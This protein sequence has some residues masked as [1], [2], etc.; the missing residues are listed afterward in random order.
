MSDWPPTQEEAS[1]LPV[2]VLGLRLLTRVR[3]SGKTTLNNVAANLRA[4]VSVRQQREAQPTGTVSGVVTRALGS[5]TSSP[6]PK[7]GI[8]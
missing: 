5:T 7:P 6:S 1:E 2:D 8:G 3:D 4:E